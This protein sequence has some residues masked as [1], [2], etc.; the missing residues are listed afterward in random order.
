MPILVGALIALRKHRLDKDCRHAKERGKPHP[1]NRPRAAHRNGRGNTGEVSCAHLGR[2][3]SRKRLK[4][5]HAR[6]V[7]FLAENLDV[8]EHIV[9]GAREAL[10]LDKAQLQREIDAGADK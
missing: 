9:H 4:R 8:R 1:E 7:S 2:N 10:D 3:G 6:A 5:S